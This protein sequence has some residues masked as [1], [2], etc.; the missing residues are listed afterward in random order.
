V[1]SGPDLLGLFASTGD[2]VHQLLRRAEGS[3]DSPALGV[4]SVAQLG[5]HL[6][7]AA[8]TTAEYLARPADPEAA[9][10][11]DASAYMRAYL[12]GGDE[13]RSAVAR[14]AIEQTV[15]L[16]SPDQ[17]PEAFDRALQATLRA[18]A[19]QAAPLPVVPTPFGL[20]A[21]D[22]Y[23]VTRV[24]EL[25]VHGLDLAEALAIAWN[26]PPGTVRLCLRLLADVASADSDDGVALLGALTGRNWADGGAL[27]ILR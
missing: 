5:A 22:Q 16:G 9:T 19:P 6:V 18:I 26:P 17:I 24:F 23:L 13:G 10:L 2:A 12:E 21:L 11:S 4:W 1:R 15:T 20:L 25:T 14:R 8:G 7:R 27:P 3:W